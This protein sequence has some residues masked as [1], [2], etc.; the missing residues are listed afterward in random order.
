MTPLPFLMEILA[1]V[2]ALIRLRLKEQG[3]DAGTGRHDA[4]V[5]AGTAVGIGWHSRDFDFVVQRLRD[6]FVC[7]QHEQSRLLKESSQGVE[8]GGGRYKRSETEAGKDR[9]CTGV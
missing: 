7:R 5:T 8:T 9:S 2:D 1:E 6:A 4:L 3:I